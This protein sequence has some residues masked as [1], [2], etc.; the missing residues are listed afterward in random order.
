[1]MDAEDIVKMGIQNGFDEVVVSAFDAKRSYLKI[2]N[3]KIDSI[4][5]KY[6]KYATLFVSS[7]KRVFMTNIDGFENAYIQK[8][9][10]KTKVNINALTPKK[11]YNGIAEGTFKYGTKGC[12]FDKKLANYTNDTITEQAQIVIDSAIEHGAEVVAGTVEMGNSFNQLSTSNK[13]NVD[14]KCAFARLSVRSFK[15]GRS[16]QL[17]TATKKISELGADKLGAKT[18]ELVGLVKNSGRIKEGEY[19]IVYLQS[20]AGLLLSIANDMA[21]IGNV[22]TGGFFTGKLGKVVG[23]R[24]LTIYDDGMNPHAIGTSPYDD[25]GYPTQKTKVI[26]RGVLKNY[27]HNYSTAKKYKTES[28]GNAGLVL[29]TSNVFELE[30]RK[31]KKDV[32]ALISEMNKGI[33]IT[34]TWYTRYSNY[35]T[36][37]FSTVPRDIAI[38]VEKGEPKFAI[39][40]GDVNSMVGI[41]ITD[42]NMK[43]MKNIVCVA[44]DLMQTASW[45]SGDDYYLTPSIL[46][47]DVWVTTA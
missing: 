16:A 34:N 3:S 20:P 29:P 26:D 21:C 4:V 10:E 42:N 44:D 33:L 9:L 46:V 32:A 13:V 45:D 24:D 6:E 36:G 40:Q 15:N 31:K 5:T 7:K 22:E 41:R 27:L 28:T 8:L 47:N 35:L 14:N 1:M 11:D 19:D 30:H 2:A 17:V 12:I 43:M 25:E 37:D 39:K 23:N 18:A 38:Y